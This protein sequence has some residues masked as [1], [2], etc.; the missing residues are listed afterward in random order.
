M[1]DILDNIGRARWFSTL[2]LFSEFFQIPLEQESRKFT[3][4][5]TEQGSFQ[6]KVVPFGL[7]VGPKSFAR[8]MANLQKIQF[9]I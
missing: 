5:T 6:Y 9:E 2:D 8:M 7:N 1:D 4:F 3:S